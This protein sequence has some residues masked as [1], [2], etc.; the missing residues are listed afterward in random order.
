VDDAVPNFWRALVSGVIKLDVAAKTL[1]AREGTSVLP[2]P[3]KSSAPSALYVR[4]CYV[5]LWDYMREWIPK[6]RLD[7]LILGTPGIGKSCFLAYVAFRLF[8]D[9]VCTGM[10]YEYRKEK[11]IYCDI[12]GRSVR[13]IT[14]DRCARL[15][16]DPAVWYLVDAVEPRLR[17][18]AG[19]VTV[20]VTSPRKDLYRAFIAQIP[21]LALCMPVW[22]ADEINAAKAVCFNELSDEV[23]QQRFH[24][25]GGI[26][27]F[28][29]S[30]ERPTDALQREMDVA[31]ESI[32]YAA[33]FR[34]VGEAASADSM[35]H[36]VL[37]MIAGPDNEI[38]YRYLYADF[39]SAYVADR[40]AQRF[41]EAVRADIERW[42]AGADASPL[43]ASMRGHLWENVCHRLL[44][45]GGSFQVRRVDAAPD[46]ATSALSVAPMELKWLR[47]VTELGSFAAVKTPTYGRFTSRTTCAIDGAL[48]DGHGCVDLL[49]M[50]VSLHHGVSI[51]GLMEAV[52]ALPAA[53]PH[54]RVRLFFVV[55]ADLFARFPLQAYM[56][57]DK[58][59]ERLSAD[60][61]SVLQRVEQWALLLPLHAFEPRSRKRPADNAV[62]AGPAPKDVHRE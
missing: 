36:K 29:L 55:P 10:V 4:D 6:N 7:Y 3:L 35:P 8:S 45:R 28:V 31:V 33:M 15:L 22:S 5:A 54:R 48:S 41:E 38:P 32:E 52:S 11:A 23:V 62:A 46:A 42:V 20:F 59:A 60:E 21:G 16:C 30:V 40:V 56:R 50:T 27:R 19:C 18:T 14:A 13:T 34:F 37:H 44:A 57:G 26:P 49:Q 9:G 25:W 1:S 24:M 53:T 61:R 43:L 58:V 47:S 12:R 51:R 2:F 39:A 17:G